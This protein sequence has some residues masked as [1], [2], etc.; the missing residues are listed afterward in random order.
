MMSS[1]IFYW[2]LLILNAF[3]YIHILICVSI[4]FSMYFF[5]TFF[6]LSLSLFH[7]YSIHYECEEQIRV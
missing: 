4:T 6:P 2:I 3:I 7:C 5:Y 1:H